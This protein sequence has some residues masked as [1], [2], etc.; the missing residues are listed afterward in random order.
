M[1]YKGGTSPAVAKQLKEVRRGGE[2]KRWRVEDASGVWTRVETGFTYISSPGYGA[3]L[4]SRS[5]PVGMNP[6]P[7][8]VNHTKQCVQIVRITR[9]GLDTPVP[10]LG[11]ETST[12][13]P[14]TASVSD[15]T[16]NHE[17]GRGNLRLVGSP[18][19]ALRTKAA[20]A[21]RSV[22]RL[23]AMTGVDKGFSRRC[24]GVSHRS[25]GTMHAQATHDSELGPW[26]NV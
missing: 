26:M 16:P 25:L 20:V 2:R 5:S 10:A 19:S 4:L 12:Q 9:P 23:M 14:G 15:M 3:I 21:G 7:R 13:Q 1:S 18:D 11:E 22:C 6:E 8:L 24:C 17:W